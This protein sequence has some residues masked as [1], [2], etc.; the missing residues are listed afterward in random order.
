MRVAS[1]MRAISRGLLMSRRPST[2][3]SRSLNLRLRRRRLQLRRRTPLRATRGRPTGLPS[4]AR[5]KA[6]G[7][8]GRRLA[9]H[10]RPERRVDGPSLRGD[11]RQRRR[12]LVAGEHR[13]EAGRLRGLGPGYR[14]GPNIRCSRRSLRGCRNTVDVLR[15]AVDHEDR[16]RLHDAAQVEELVVLPERLFARPLGGALDDGDPV[17]I[18][19]MTRARRAA[20]SSGGK[21]SCPANTG[22]AIRTPDMPPG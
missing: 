19:S 22:W 9:E 2:I 8:R 21:I 5:H 3:G 12:E 7:S 17:P 14:P 1:R 16:P 15:A 18:F 13:V 10:L 6:T 20:N 11:G 4:Y